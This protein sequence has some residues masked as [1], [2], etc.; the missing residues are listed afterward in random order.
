MQR[1]WNLQGEGQELREEGRTLGHQLLIEHL[2]ML[3]TV[4]A[5][6]KRAQCSNTSEINLP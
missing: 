1:A 3:L 6:D 2:L 5:S 4:Q